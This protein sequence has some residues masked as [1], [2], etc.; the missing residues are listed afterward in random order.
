MACNEF[1]S[2]C[3]N[4]SPVL[5]CQ[6]STLSKEQID[7]MEFIAGLALMDDD[8]RRAAIEAREQA[9]NSG[10]NANTG[11]ARLVAGKRLR[12]WRGRKRTGEASGGGTRLPGS[13]KAEPHRD[14]KR[15]NRALALS[16][17]YYLVSLSCRLCR[18]LCASRLC[19]GIPDRLRNFRDGCTDKCIYRIG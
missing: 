13:P 2:A 19:G 16:V 6:P 14:G 7:Q 4:R 5:R 10:Q 15:T 9:H 1:Y 17:I 12:D 3:F 11:L 8:Q 18:S